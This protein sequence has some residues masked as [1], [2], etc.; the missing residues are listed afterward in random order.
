[1]TP[2]TTANNNHAKASTEPTTA[3]LDMT[4]T[5]TA[6]KKHAKECIEPTTDYL[7]MRPIATGNNKHAEESNEPTT[8]Y[9][10]MAPVDTTTNKHAT[11]DTELTTDYL[12]PIATA[13]R[14]NE[15]TGQL[16]TDHLTPIA[17]M[18]DQKRNETAEKA[19]KIQENESDVRKQS[20][21]THSHVYEYD[22]VEAPNN[23]EQINSQYLTVV[24]AEKPYDLPLTGY[25]S[26]GT[27]EYTK[28]T[29]SSHTYE[30]QK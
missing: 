2:T 15:S 7:R 26:P 23:A 3:Y 4:P 25:L 6:N 20:R 12:T 24:E 29:K 13:V 16:A 9:L 18:G 28:L 30:D 27:E 1:M 22:D 8:D 14:N 11:E 5:A 21:D 19:P 17:R 10:H